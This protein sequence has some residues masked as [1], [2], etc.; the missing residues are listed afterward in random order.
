MYP[1]SAIGPP[2]PNAPRRRKYSA[3]SRSEHGASSSV[4]VCSRTNDTAC[5]VLF[6]RALWRS[7]AELQVVEIRHRVGFRPQPDAAGLRKRRVAHVQ[8]LLAVDAGFEM[9]AGHA[10]FEQMPGAAG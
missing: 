7:R 5:S 4:A 6:G 2:K 1:A 9:V 3:M 8:V 10:H